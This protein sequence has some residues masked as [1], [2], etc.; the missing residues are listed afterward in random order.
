MSASIESQPNKDSVRWL[1]FA[2]QFSNQLGS[3]FDCNIQLG[4]I[5]LLDVKTNPERNRVT[6]KPDGGYP[7]QLQTT[8]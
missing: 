4:T 3:L 6:S 5:F 8:V 7:K 2:N 1:E